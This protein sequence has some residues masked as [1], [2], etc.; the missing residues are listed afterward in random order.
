FA[1]MKGVN[2]EGA[3]LL[4]A[5]L[6]GADLTGARVKG[7]DFTDAD[8]ASAKLKDLIGVAGSNLEQAANNLNQAF[9]K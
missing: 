4:R 1:S 7:A 2:L 6:G 5:E 3:N 9:R 8:V